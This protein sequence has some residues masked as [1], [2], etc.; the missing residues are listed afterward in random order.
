[1][2]DYSPAGIPEKGA[3][4]Y[5][6]QTRREVQFQR[7]ELLYERLFGEALLYFYRN[8][9]RFGDWQAV[10]I[11]PDR[12][13]E[14]TDCYPYRSLL[15]SEQVQRVYLNEL[16]EA[17]QLP[18]EVALMLLTTASEAQAPGAARSLLSRV[19]QEAIAAERKQAIIGVV[20]TIL[21]YQFTSLSRVEIEAMLDI[22]FAETRLYQDVKQEG[23][24]EEAANLIVRLLNRR[25]QQDLS[26]ELRSQITALPL[27]VL[28]DLAEALLDFS[29]LAEL[30]AWLA[31][32]Q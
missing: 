23:R 7:D 10:V 11:Y 4:Q 31:A 6:S 25:L 15:N 29:T 3:S 30:E 14:Q 26:E 8:R 13:V 2:G 20:V 22:R 27:P 1:V 21:S 28:E 16:G 18:I 19:E 5:P 17:S 32:H 24:Q 12:A 9:R